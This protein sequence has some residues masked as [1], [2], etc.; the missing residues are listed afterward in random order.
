MEKFAV[1]IP[2]YN[3][4]YN[5]LKIAEA[6]ESLELQYLITD[7]GSTDRTATHL[8]LKN[9]PAL[10]YFP[11]RGKAFALQLGSRYLIKEGY[12]YILTMDADGQHSIDDIEKFD[13]ALLFNE[14]CDIIIG[15]RMW[16]KK[17][18]PK[19]RYWTNKFMSFVISKI[20]GQTI[21]DTQCGFRMYSKRIFEELICDSKGFTF[22]NEVLI[23]ASRKGYKIK[24]VPVK[25]I[26]HKE[27]K[28]NIKIIRELFR[29]IKL[30]CK[31][32]LYK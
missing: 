4:E 17:S 25:C 31:S 28:S 3:E 8:W 12:K 11:N 24:S 26:Y 20:S 19:I 9:I 14:D 13:N 10:C 23:K 6:M 21:E 22:E 16:D 29:F 2:A 1:L 30:I 15:N 32:L 27:R 7:D 18:M 5:I